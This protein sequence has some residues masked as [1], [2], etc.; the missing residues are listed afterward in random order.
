MSIAPARLGLVSP[1]RAL[2]GSSNERAIVL[3]RLVLG[4][5]ISH[6]TWTKST[7]WNIAAFIA[8]GEVERCRHSNNPISQTVDEK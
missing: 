6:R 7:N 3:Y 1:L 2:H 5:L 4:M 8:V